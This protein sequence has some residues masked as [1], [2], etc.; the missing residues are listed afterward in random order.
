MDAPVER[1]G[2]TAELNREPEQLARLCRILEIEG[3]GDRTLGFA[4]LR[5]PNGRGFWAYYFRKLARAEAAGHP[6]IATERV[7]LTG[8]R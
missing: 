6:A 2:L 5:D 7:P 3:H 1:D 8:T 4:S